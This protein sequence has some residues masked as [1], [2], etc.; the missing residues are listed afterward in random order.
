MTKE[1]YPLGET[2]PLGEEPQLMLA[3]CI[4]KSRFGNPK[5]ALKIEKIPVPAELKPHEVLVYIMAAGV[6]Y[7]VIWASSGVPVD[8]ID[9][10]NK[11]KGYTEDFHIPGS[12][13]AGV[14]WK[15]GSA[16][17]NV[18]IGDEVIIHG[19]RWDYEDPH[20]K[21]GKDPTFAPS[22]HMWGYETIYGGLAQYTRVQDHQ[23][24]PKAKHLTWAE[25]GSFMV[26]GA[27]AYRML[28]N[29]AGN[30]VQENDPV[31]IW[32][33]AGGLGCMAIQ[34]CKVAGARPVAVVSDPQKFDYC[35]NLGAVGV[36]NRKEF[37]HWGMLPHW[38]DEI[39]YNAWAKEARRFGKAF[40]EALGEK[41]NPVIVF[42]HPGEDTM[43]TSCFVAETG[44]MVVSCAGT[45][46]FNATIDIRYHW[47]RQKR[48]Q[49]SHYANDEQCAAISQLVAD[50]KVDPCVSRVFQFEETSEAHQLIYLN[51]HS[52]GNS[53]ILVNALSSGQQSLNK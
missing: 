18:K 44:G 16:V 40:W 33:G 4:R 53:V 9:Y 31:L 51:H 8:V 35:L 14:V 13:A 19:C 21:A 50:G 45:S 15:I 43:P 12:D 23:C 32:G 37:N 2:P 48:F 38:Q 17:K 26:N 20:I 49:G 7:N 5:D 1:F 52:S 3:N 28:Y 10:C 41:R 6:N 36:I 27:A 30:I 42:E 46:G 22:L 39:K 34:I 11:K 29:W 24:L 47:M 25:A